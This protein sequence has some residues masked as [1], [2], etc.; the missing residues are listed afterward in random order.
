MS[1]GGDQ[2]T[3]VTLGTVLAILGIPDVEIAWIIP[4]IVR[5]CQVSSGTFLQNFS[6]ALRDG[7]QVQVYWQDRCCYSVYYRDKEVL[8]S[9]NFISAIYGPVIWRFGADLFA[10]CVGS[11][12][13]RTL[14]NRAG[15]LDRVRFLRHKLRKKKL[16]IQQRLLP[17]PDLAPLVLQ[18]L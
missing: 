12:Q 10:F 5:H 15:L 1:T 9:S 18:F 6:T 2:G 16:F 7:A 11:Q 17:V 3:M 4:L 13:K 8:V 14:W